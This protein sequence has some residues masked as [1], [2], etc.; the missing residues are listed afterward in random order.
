[1]ALLKPKNLIV[2]L[3]N[4]CGEILFKVKAWVGFQEIE[5]FRASRYQQSALE[6]VQL[7]NYSMCKAV[8]QLYKFVIE[9]KA[10]FTFS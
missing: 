8:N 3:R 10:K 9:N 5:N 2:R 7:C 4:V 1:M 6:E